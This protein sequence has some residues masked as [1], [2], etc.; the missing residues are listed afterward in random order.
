MISQMGL[1]PIIWP[2]FPNNCIKMKKFGWGE[3]A[4]LDPPFRP[5]NE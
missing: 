5:A 4:S 3:Q 1:Q 2:I